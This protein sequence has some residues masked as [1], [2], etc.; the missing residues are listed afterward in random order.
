MAKLECLIRKCRQ[1]CTDEGFKRQ[2]VQIDLKTY[3]VHGDMG[4]SITKTF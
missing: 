2:T 3:Q 1:I 4:C